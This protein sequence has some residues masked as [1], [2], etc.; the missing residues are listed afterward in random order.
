[1]FSYQSML[2]DKGKDCDKRVSY[3]YAQFQAS[4]MADGYN[5]RLTIHGYTVTK[6]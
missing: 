3:T 2:K 4:P 6:S 5:N 1:M